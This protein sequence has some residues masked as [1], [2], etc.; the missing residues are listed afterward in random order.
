M[1]EENENVFSKAVMENFTPDAPAQEATPQKQEDPPPPKQEAQ[2]DSKQEESPQEMN[3][4]ALRES[5]KELEQ[6]FKELEATRTDLES[7]L[8]QTR[9]ELETARV[10]FNKEELLSKG[11][12]Q[13][14]AH[15]D[16]M[17]G[18]DDMDIMGIGADG[19]ETPVFVNGQ[20]AWE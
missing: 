17:I 13:S 10:E 9:T 19:S 5:K 3:F 8:N 12:N 14:A 2:E 15:V 18:T 7:Q 6:K 1:S 20:W 4:K 16:F 11:V